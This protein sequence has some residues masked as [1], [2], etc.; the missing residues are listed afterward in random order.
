MRPSMAGTLAYN[1]PFWT[2]SLMVARMRF[3]AALWASGGFSRPSG[4][5]ASEWVWARA[6]ML[7]RMNES[8]KKMRGIRRDRSRETMRGMACSHCTPARRR[9][10]GSASPPAVVT[11][12]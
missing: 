12:C 6:D 1:S 8:A 3:S 9:V 7:I 11:E 2:T 4:A 5:R 10:A